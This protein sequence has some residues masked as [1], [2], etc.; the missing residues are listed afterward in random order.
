MLIIIFYD[1]FK[2]IFYQSVTN[3]LHTS[4]IVALHNF[5]GLAL[6]TLL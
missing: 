6:V 4:G 5:V 1:I 2:F 3:I